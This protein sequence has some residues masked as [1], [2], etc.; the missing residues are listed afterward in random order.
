MFDEN[1]KA[2]RKAN[3]LEENDF[4]DSD[5]D[6]FFDRTGDLDAKREKRRKALRKRPEKVKALSHEEITGKLTEVQKELEKLEKQ[7]D[8]D[9]KIRSL[10]KASD[11]PLDAFM[12]QVN[13]ILTFENW[14]PDSVGVNVI[15]TNLKFSK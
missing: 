4:Y 1:V 15:A 5:E 8:K 3:K 7:M 9:K 11:D 12:K 14:N 6:S 10:T 13:I 2:R